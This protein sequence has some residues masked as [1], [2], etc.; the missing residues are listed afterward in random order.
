MIKFRHFDLWPLKIQKGQVHAIV[1]ICMGKSIRMKRV[2]KI[3]LNMPMTMVVSDTTERRP[4]VYKG[5][6][7][8]YCGCGIIY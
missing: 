4:T 3:I 2:F 5:E 6:I 7:E 1:S 8:R